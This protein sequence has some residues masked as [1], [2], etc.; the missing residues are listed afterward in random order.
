MKTKILLAIGAI[1]LSLVSFV[2]GFRLAVHWLQTGYMDS[3]GL[4][5]SK[6]D[7]TLGRGVC[8][9]GDEMLDLRP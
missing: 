5:R 4:C 7:D 3:K 2:G 6:W 1:L 9:Y 8:D